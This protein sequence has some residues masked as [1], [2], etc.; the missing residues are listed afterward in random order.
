MPSTSPS[1]RIEIPQSN[2]AT[3]MLTNW[4]SDCCAGPL[5]TSA[6]A[7]TGWFLRL[8]LT[9]CGLALSAVYPQ[10]QVASAVP[11]IRRPL[12]GRPS[13]AATRTDDPPNI[14]GRL[15]DPVWRMATRITEFVQERPF[16]GAPATEQ[17]EVY[18]AYDSHKIYFGIYAHYS[19]VGLIRANRVDRDQTERDDTVQVFF[20]PFLDQQRGYIFS[21]NGYGV[22]GD[23]LIGSRQPGGGSGG[24]T[25]GGRGGAG[26]SDESWDA[27]FASA[28]T[29]V[30]DGWTAEMAIPFK[31][32]RYPARGQ[33]EVHRWGFQ[34]QRD[35]QSK[36]ESVVWA[37]VSRDI[38]GLLRQMGVL[39]GLTNL[40]TSRNL[41]LLP[42]MTAIQVG[43][44]DRT[45]GIYATQHLEEGGVNVKYGITPNLTFDFSYNPDFSQIESDRP[46]IEINQRFPLLYPEL[47]PFFLEGQEIFRIMG[48]MAVHTRAIVDPQYGA[49]L[50]GKVGKTTL[51]IVVA[52]DKAAGKVDSR[53]DPAFGRAA[54][55]LLGRVRYDLYSESYFGWIVTDREFLDSYSRVGGFDGAFRLGR[56]HRLG[57]MG[58]SATIAIRRESGAPATYS[59]HT[60]A[61][62]DAT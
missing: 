28:G 34:I 55:F 20:D 47:R 36:D 13:I 33:G 11:P 29:L 32:L 9:A 45:T 4:R 48:T 27:L 49:K 24:S 62:K 44:L 42:T 35:I 52:N 40:S 60:F 23:R 38:P 54:Q 46:Q 14:D 43:N 51:G 17:T 56:N 12:A 31:S 30:E 50:T 2:T 37:P 6:P 61:R 10:A 53:N 5:M 59:T 3:W 19:D 26:G 41:E 21:V 25:G 39:E 57:S 18:I 22:Q 7:V 58:W 8:T 15:A 1:I 16:E